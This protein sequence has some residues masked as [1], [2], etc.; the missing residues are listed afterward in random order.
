MGGHSYPGNRDMKNHDAL[1][2]GTTEIGVVRS[3]P[4]LH[5]R[6]GLIPKFHWRSSKEIVQKWEIES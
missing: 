5:A 2:M 3:S 6:Y 4:I 1:E